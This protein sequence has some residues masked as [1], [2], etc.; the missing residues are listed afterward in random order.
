MKLNIFLFISI[1]IL[2][3]NLNNN[4]GGGV[5]AKDVL[6]GKFRGPCWGRDGKRLC[7]HLCNLE[8]HKSGYCSRFPK[9]Q[10]WCRFVCKFYFSITNFAVMKINNIVCSNNFFLALIKLFKLEKCCLFICAFSIS[11]NNCRDLVLNDEFNLDMRY[12]AAYEL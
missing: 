6:S 10:C 5:L 8:R 11:R 9:S 12:T 1:I 2:I 7:E 4:N 3:I